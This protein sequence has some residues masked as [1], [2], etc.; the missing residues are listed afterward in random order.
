MDTDLSMS[1]V[2]A[3]AAATQHAIAIAVVK[4]SHEMEMA[5]VQMLDDAARAS[6][7]AGQGRIVD[8]LA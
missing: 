8:K 2:A 6:P 5:L 3:R 4:K 7:P 1:L